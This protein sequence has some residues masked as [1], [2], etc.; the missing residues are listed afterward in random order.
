LKPAP[1]NQSHARCTFWQSIFNSVNILMGIGMLSLPLAFS[2]TGWVVGVGLLVL[3][4]LV[5]M[6]T[7]F[8]LAR[9]LDYSPPTGWSLEARSSLHVQRAHTF[10]DIGELAFGRAG[11][12]VI[13]SL[14]MLELGAACVALVILV[15]DSLVALCPVLQAH[16]ISTKLGLVLLVMMPSTFPT[17]LRYAS[18]GS[19]L[20][21]VSLGLVLVAMFFQ[22]TV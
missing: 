1:T 5:T 10:G 17:S 7:A 6:Y 14:F 16:P 18:Y 3:S 2:I 15:S 4:A 22:G 9:C 12:T 20:G 8:L 11:R 19:L 13:N 21:I